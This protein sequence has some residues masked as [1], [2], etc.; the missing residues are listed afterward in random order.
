MLEYLEKNVINNFWIVINC[1]TAIFC[2]LYLYV[3]QRDVK[4]QNK[5]DFR[6]I[7]RSMCLRLDKMLQ[8][9]IL[10]VVLIIDKQ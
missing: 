3:R 7:F 4:S 10:W 5:M 6:E 1:F 2:N 9:D 8:A